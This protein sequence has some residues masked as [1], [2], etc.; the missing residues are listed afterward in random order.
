MHMHCT[1]TLHCSKHSTQP[2]S[3]LMLDETEAWLA[4]YMLEW[5]VE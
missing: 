4:G 1:G 2:L 3:R 5:Q